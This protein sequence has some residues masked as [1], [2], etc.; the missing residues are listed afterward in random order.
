MQRFIKKIK[1][2]TEDLDELNH[3]NNVRFVQWIQD[4]AKSHWESKVT[5]EIEANYFWVVLNH[6]ITY[7][8]SAFLNDV[9]RIETYVTESEGFK[10]KRIVEMYLQDSNKLL[11]SSETLWCFM[12]K[13]TKKPTRITPDVK[14]LFS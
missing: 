14:A 13:V 1:V 9:I 7:K 6:N 8:N 10:S 11:V 3:V 2:Q 4:V 12:D 5:P